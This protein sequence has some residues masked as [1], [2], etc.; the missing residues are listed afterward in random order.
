MLYVLN[1]WEVMC[2]KKNLETRSWI[3]MIIFEKKKDVIFKITA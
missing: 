3:F 1:I 2:N